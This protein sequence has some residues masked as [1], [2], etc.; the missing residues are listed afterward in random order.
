VQ[1][2]TKVLWLKTTMVCSNCGYDKRTAEVD[3]AAVH[4]ADIIFWR[5]LVPVVA[6]IAVISCLIQTRLDGVGFLVF[7]AFLGICGMFTVIGSRFHNLEERTCFLC[8][9]TF[10]LIGIVRIIYGLSIG[11]HRFEFL[12]A[13]MILIPVPI[14]AAASDQG[15]LGS[16]GG[17]GCGGG[18]GG[19]G[20]CGGGGGGGGG[21]CGGCG[22]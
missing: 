14:A 12:I 16:H 3:K 10:E 13:M 2:K 15:V 6:I 7:F 5:L 22:G 21:G 17:G 11:M 20:G 9:I 19:G 18:G 4:T 8:L 1:L